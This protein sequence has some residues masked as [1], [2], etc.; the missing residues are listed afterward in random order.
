MFHIESLEGCKEAAQLLDITYVKEVNQRI[1]LKGCVHLLGNDGL[2]WNAAT[3]VIQTF[4]SRNICLDGI[5][6]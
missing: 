2:F 5:Y 6:L 4:I 3:D 1:A